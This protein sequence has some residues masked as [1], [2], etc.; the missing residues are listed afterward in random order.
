MTGFQTVPHGAPGTAAYRSRGDLTHALI[1]K[2]GAASDLSASDQQAVRELCVDIRRVPA[3][4]NILRPD[5]RP[6]HVHVMLSGWAARYVLQK[7][8]SRQIVAFLI[9]GDFCDL[10]V[11]ILGRMDHGIVTLTPAVVGYVSGA[12]MEEL[13]HKRP[14]LLR[15]LW[16]AG[17]IDESILRA[18]IA[19]IGRRDAAQGM[20]HLFCELHTR[21]QLVGLI[22]DDSLPLPVTQE[23]LADALGITPVHA[24]RTLHKLR[25]AGLIR[26]KGG[27]LEIPDLPALKAFAGFTLG[28][29]HQAQLKRTW[30]R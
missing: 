27:I 12:D 24:N 28:Y 25:A 18:W 26:L 30:D 10:H 29:L 7:D 3:K 1:A 5:E 11:T 19:N 17:L 15:A 20:A 13:P 9:P 16:R 21:L 8:G 6:S 4:K 23:D 14:N 22:D 2:L